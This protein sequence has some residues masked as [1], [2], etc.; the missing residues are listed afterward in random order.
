MTDDFDGDARPQGGGYDIGADELVSASASLSVSPPALAFAKVVGQPNP[1]A[2]NVAIT[3]PA[4]QG[5]T[6]STPASWVSLGTSSGSGSA[7]VP[8]SPSSGMSSLTA[9]TYMSSISVT[10]AGLSAGVSLSVVVSAASAETTIDFDNPSPP[11]AAGGKLGLFGGIKWGRTWCWWS[12]QPGVDSSNHAAFCK[13]KATSGAFT[14]S[15]GPRTLT[16]ITLV[17]SVAGTATITDSNG[18]TITATLAPGQNVAMATNW[19]Q[20]STGVKLSSAAGSHMAITAL[21]YK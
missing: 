20:P 8:V 15:S 4:G 13:A 18:R 6:A 12:A 3:V 11:G 19:T 16:S 7:T 1:P 14:F 10:S 5:W 9:G 21:T 17:S 2:Q